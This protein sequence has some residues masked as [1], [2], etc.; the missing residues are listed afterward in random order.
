MA[1]VKVTTKE[2]AERLA[3]MLEYM[4]DD[5]NDPDDDDIND[6]EDDQ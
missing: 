2:D 5:N 6:N 1:K 3:A 4:R